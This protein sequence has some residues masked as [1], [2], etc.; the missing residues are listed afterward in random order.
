MPSRPLPRPKTYEPD[1]AA[2]QAATIEAAF[3]QHLLPWAD[4]PDEVQQRLRR[5]QGELTRRSLQ[6][7]IDKGLMSR[8]EALAVERRLDL[9]D[10]PQAAV[11]SR[12]DGPTE[13]V[14]P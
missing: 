1:Q 8:E 5:L 14:R 12:P 11:P 2:C 13:A 3:R 9:P 4:Q 7:C 10:S 6:R